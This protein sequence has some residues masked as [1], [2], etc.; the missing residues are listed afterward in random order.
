MSSIK[1]RVLAAGALALALVGVTTAPA[2]AA[3]AADG[4]PQR[5]T[6]AG[7]DTT[8]DVMSD[9][10]AAWNAANAANPDPDTAHNVPVQANAADPAFTVPAD[11]TCTSPSGGRSYVNKGVADGINTF[12]APNGSTDGRNALAGTGN[13]RPGL[14]WPTDN[15]T[16]GCIDI[17][18]S[19]SPPSGSDPAGFQ[20][21]AFA[22]DA[23]TWA[24]FDGAAPDSRSLTVDQLRDIYDCDITNWNEVGGSDQQIQ[25]YLPQ[26]GSG[27]LSFFTG[28][29]LGFN[30]ITSQDIIDKCNAAEAPPVIQI[31][32][33]DLDG[34][35]D[36]AKDAAISPF[37]VAQ[38][39]AQGNG[40]ETDKRNGAFLGLQAGMNPVTGTDGGLAPNPDVIV[41]PPFNSFEGVRF[42]YNVIDTAQAHDGQALRMVGFDNTGPGW[43]CDP[44]SA[45][46]TDIINQQGFMR[47]EDA[48]FP[49][50]HC[51]GESI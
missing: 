14:P 10:A 5:L 50:H 45:G 7:S 51:R 27:T 36:E 32:E 34:I 38:W 23:V 17:A 37:S 47:L 12:P 2:Y 26:N 40:K 42:V 29:V 35:D 39:V 43:L 13:A 22:L 19:S 44:D 18:R 16:T 3:P 28:T 1:T 11:G 20:Y 25:R 4:V 49:N 41:E 24:A 48:G 33:H 8:E 31:Q 46:V 6:I 9:L 30:P 15:P 21:Y